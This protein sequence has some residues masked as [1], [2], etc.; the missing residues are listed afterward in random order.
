MASFCGSRFNE[1]EKDM[2][3]YTPELGRRIEAR[4]LQDLGKPRH[5][6]YRCMEY[7]KEIHGAFGLPLPPLELS[8]RKNQMDDPPIGYAMYLLVRNPKLQK[9]RKWSHVGLIISGHRLIH[10]SYY[11]GMAVVVTPFKDI[12]E[13][14][15]LVEVDLEYIEKVRNQHVRGC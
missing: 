15:H 9:G 11:M 13:Q 10:N 14:Y 6:D 7:V 3:V 1:E 4:A 5:K 2:R 12:F 8:V